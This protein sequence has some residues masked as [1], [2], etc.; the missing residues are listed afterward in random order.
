MHQ[1][2]LEIIQPD[3]L[4]ERQITLIALPLSTI[5]SKRFFKHPKPPN[6]EGTAKSSV[7]HHSSQPASTRLR[8]AHDCPQRIEAGMSKG[9]W[10]HTGSTLRHPLPPCIVIQR[11]G[12]FKQ[13]NDSKTSPRHVLTCFHQGHCMTGL[14]CLRSQPKGDGIHSAAISQ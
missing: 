12:H 10:R 14:S 13:L 6:R 7:P 5:P 11:D 8:T 2:V 4:H 9:K 3:N 1:L